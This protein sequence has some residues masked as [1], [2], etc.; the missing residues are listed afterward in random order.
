MAVA[1]CTEY[2]VFAF[3]ARRTV[4]RW[5]TNNLSL[6]HSEVTVLTKTLSLQPAGCTPLQCSQHCQ[7][8]SEL[9]F[10][11]WILLASVSTHL[12]NRITWVRVLSGSGEEPCCFGAGDLVD[13]YSTSSGGNSEN[14]KKA[15]RCRIT[16]SN[17]QAF[18]TRP[19][20]AGPACRRYF[21]GM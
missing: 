7:G 5:T 2:L 3:Y 19:P 20:I 16:T 12:C 9:V 8:N 4:V 13:H 18:G 17:I 1:L 15:S 21:F 6:G 11:R 10:G 14:G